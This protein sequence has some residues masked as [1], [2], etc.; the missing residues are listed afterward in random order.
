RPSMVNP[1]RPLNAPANPTAIRIPVL[2]SLPNLRDLGGYPTRGGGRVRPGLVYR[3]T[4]LAGIEGADAEAFAR[5]GI[6]AVYDLRTLG[7]RTAKPDRLPPGTAYVVTDVLEASA[8]PAP[9]ELMAV[10]ESPELARAA[11][12]DGRAATFFDQAYREFVSLDSARSAYRRLFSDLVQARHRPALFHCST[13]KDRTG[14]AAAALLMFLDVADEL[15]MADYLLSG[16]RLLVSLQP[17]LDDFRDR[18]GDPEIL[19]PIL[20]V[21]PEYLEVAIDE[22]RR[23][24]GSIDGYFETGLGIGPAAGGA[25]RAALTEPG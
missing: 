11:F 1:S 5:L 12:G 19:R 6:R 9:A 21:R 3:S 18:G 2:A 24:F 16:D 22:M 14:W 7:E 17:V 25:L 20:D 4:D 23:M 13:G 15:V 8:Q 10:L